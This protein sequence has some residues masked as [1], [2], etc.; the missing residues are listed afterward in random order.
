MG[1][2]KFRCNAKIL[3]ILQFKQLWGRENEKFTGK[4]G[5]N[6][7]IVYEKSWR[8]E[9]ENTVIID[10][11]LLLNLELSSQFK[12]WHAGC[13]LMKPSDVM[14]HADTHPIKSNDVSNERW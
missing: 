8:D 9:K 14:R 6:N 2:G 7:T 1:Q 4:C 13:N 3:L 12:N 5:K 11:K 10:G